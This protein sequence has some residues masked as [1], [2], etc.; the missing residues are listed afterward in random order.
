M[1]IFQAVSQADTVR[2]FF[3][4]TQIRL[5]VLIAFDLM[6]GQT[7]KFTKEYRDM[8]NLLYLESGGYGVRKGRA[9]VTLA[10]YLQYLQ[11][12]GHLYDKV[13]SFDDKH[14]EFAHNL[15][16]LTFLAHN[17]P[18]I[19]KNLMPVIHEPGDY[20]QEISIL[21]HEGYDHIAIG[22]PKKIK[23]EVFLKTQAE[24]PQVK[25]HLLGKLNRQILTNHKPD[26][27]DAHPRG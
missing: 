18:D 20:L 17:L 3:E 11:R 12:H 8:I 1:R 22:T 4:R 5:N 27:A 6:A 19:Q 13:T 23:D 7:D 14:N 16:N 25:F 24:L 2:K 9:K 21:V 26:S 15:N 10:D